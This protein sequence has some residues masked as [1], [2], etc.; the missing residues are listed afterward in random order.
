[1]LSL[2]FLNI[3]SDHKFPRFHWKVTFS[4]YVSFNKNVF[5]QVEFWIS[6]IWMQNK[7]CTP[8]CNHVKNVHQL[9]L[10][11]I[12]DLKIQISPTWG[13]ILIIRQINIETERQR[14]GPADSHVCDLFNG[15]ILNVIANTRFHMG[16]KVS[17]SWTHPS[18]PSL[19]VIYIQG[20]CYCRYSYAQCVRTAC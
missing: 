11:Q 1:M 3:N 2:V 20:I 16:L 17:R 4:H 9:N 19:H 5:I 10:K 8:S 18:T 14:D 15:W 7:V 12:K 6:A 13:I